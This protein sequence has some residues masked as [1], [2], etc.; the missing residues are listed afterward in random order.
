MLRYHFDTV[1]N[2]K[3]WARYA[4]P[5]LLFTR[6]KTHETVGWAKH[7]VPIK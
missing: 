2:Q 3:R 5:I 1:P 6:V 4:L 7:S